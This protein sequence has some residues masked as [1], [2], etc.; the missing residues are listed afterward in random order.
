VFPAAEL[1]VIVT[2]ESRETSAVSHKP[3]L[4][5]AD[6]NEALCKLLNVSLQQTGFDVWL[7]SSAYEALEIY[8]HHREWIDL[9]L[10]DLCLS[11]GQFGIEMLEALQQISGDVRCCFMTDRPAGRLET[12]LYRRG[13]VAVFQKPLLI[14]E[15]SRALWRLASQ[16]IRPSCQAA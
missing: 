2:E 11:G 4:L 12:E 3:V 16:R 9:F 5:V 15:L 14:D 13:A 7:A 8:R 1:E 6:E 10:I